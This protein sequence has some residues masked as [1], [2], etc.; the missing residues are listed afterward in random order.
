MIFS[1][2]LL[3]LG[4]VVRYLSSAASMSEN[5]KG[6]LQVELMTLKEKVATVGYNLYQQVVAFRHERHLVLLEYLFYFMS[7]HT[8]YFHQGY[9]TMKV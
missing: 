4:V 5:E 2:S 9:H 7:L 8:S 3:K 6:K 1:L